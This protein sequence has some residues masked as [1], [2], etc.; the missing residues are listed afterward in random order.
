MQL[1]KAQFGA[2][3]VVV[4]GRNAERLDWLRGVGA[5]DGPFGSAPKIWPNALPPNIGSQP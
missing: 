1:A 3:R 4:A 2:G 5:D